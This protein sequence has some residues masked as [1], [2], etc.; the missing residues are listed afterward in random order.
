MVYRADHLE[1]ADPD[2]ALQERLAAAIYECGRQIRAARP[3]LD[4]QDGSHGL[5]AATVAAVE[6]LLSLP[7]ST[8]RGVARAVGVDAGVVREIKAGSY[9]RRT[10]AERCPD[11]GGAVTHP[12]QPCRLCAE[13]LVRSAR[14][15]RY[16]RDSTTPLNPFLASESLAMITADTLLRLA[17][18]VE[19]SQAQLQLLASLTGTQFD[20]W[21]VKLLVHLSQ[22]RDLINE[23]VAWLNWV[24]LVRGEG[25]EQ[26]PR[27]M[28]PASFAP[29]ES[30]LHRLQTSLLA[31]E[32]GS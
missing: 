28:L 29:F 26:D 19:Q 21:L 12:D 10:S 22:E 14:A 32:L 15:T 7:T 16:G 6:R 9:V 2:P 30:N 17:D 25:G 13:K 4:R 11:C 23:V 8:I 20:D 3:A 27:P 18:F 5:P 31:A 1:P 24:G